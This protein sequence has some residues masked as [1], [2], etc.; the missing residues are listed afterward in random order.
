MSPLAKEVIE[1]LNKEEDV[2]V[3]AEVL[4]FYEY[5]KH[6]NDKELETR[7]SRIDEDEATE[8]ENKLCEQYNNSKEELIPL[9]NLIKELNLGE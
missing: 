8:N 7:W 3:L 1:K 5:L 2:Q 4:D 6:K 9:E